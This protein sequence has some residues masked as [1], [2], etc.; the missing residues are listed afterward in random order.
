MTSGKIIVY[1]EPTSPFSTCRNLYHLCAPLNSIPSLSLYQLQNTTSPLHLVFSIPIPPFR[2]SPCFA[3]FFLTLR[4]SISSARISVTTPAICGTRS[5]AVWLKL[6]CAFR[7]AGGT[8]IPNQVRG[9]RGVEGVE[10]SVVEFGVEAERSEKDSEEGRCSGG[11]GRGV[12]ELALG[13]VWR[14]NV[15]EEDGE[16]FMHLVE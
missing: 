15:G 8:R 1:F 13:V 16:G 7:S 14:E 2:P 11:E 10:G 9:S 6:R 12:E 4:T 3:I 5:R